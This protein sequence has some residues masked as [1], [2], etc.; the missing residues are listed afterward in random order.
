MRMVMRNAPGVDDVDTDTFMMM[1][2]ATPR[3]DG[4]DCSR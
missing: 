3:V 2:T 4:D 1:M